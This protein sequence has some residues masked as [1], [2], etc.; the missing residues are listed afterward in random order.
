[1]YHSHSCGCSR[2]S[3]GPG[4]RTRNLGDCTKA[5]PLAPPPATPRPCLSGRAR[6]LHVGLLQLLM[7]LPLLPALRSCFSTPPRICWSR[8]P[9]RR[10]RTRPWSPP[11]PTTWTSTA[12]WWAA[13]LQDSAAWLPALLRTNTEWHHTQRL[14]DVQQPVLNW[15]YSN[16]IAYKLAPVHLLYNMQPSLSSINVL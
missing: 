7:R 2:S 14:F 9:G 8:Y 13:W 10:P 15:K 3:V 4:D 6:S 5:V 11:P 12:P 1:M 16:V